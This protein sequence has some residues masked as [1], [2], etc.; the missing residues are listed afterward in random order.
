ML[1]V[2]QPEPLPPPIPVPPAIVA[3]GF[4]NPLAFRI[5]AMTA[6]I[7]LLLNVVMFPACPLWLTAAG[8]LGVYLYQRRSGQFLST[9]SGAMMGW[10]TGVMSFVV[11]SIPVIFGYVK[12][13][14]APDF[15]AQ[16]REQMSQ[17][18]FFTPAL[19]D[20]MV[21]SVQTTSGVVTQVLVLLVTLFVLFTLFPL[22]GGV[23]GSKVLSKE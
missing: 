4:R 20:Q 3:V 10:I 21:A 12:Q 23:L 22:L 16:L 1:A 7:A 11:T 5:G 8:F 18:P 17:Y 14:T 19:Q 6:L 15:A 9:R 13:I 2:E